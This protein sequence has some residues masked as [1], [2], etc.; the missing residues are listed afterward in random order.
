[1]ADLLTLE[2]Y[3]LFVKKTLRKVDDEN[4]R[5]LYYSNILLPGASASIRA[6]F[7]NDFQSI[8][9]SEIF[10]VLEPSFTKLFPRYRP[11]SSLTSVII[12]GLTLASSTVKLI[13]KEQAFVFDLT[14]F[15]PMGVEHITINYVGGFALTQ[16]QRWAIAQLISRL[17]DEKVETYTTTSEVETAITTQIEAD[18]MIRQMFNQFSRPNI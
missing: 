2:E 18:T 9:R 17:D 13:S 5:D 16:G 8:A 1:M 12:N 10:S 3:K 4:E 7:D 14:C 11:V 6:F 15:W